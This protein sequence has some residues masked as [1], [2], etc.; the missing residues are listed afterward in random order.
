M[1]SISSFEAFT[2]VTRLSERVFRVVENDRFGQFPFMYVIIGS[3]KCILIDTG[4]GSSDYRQFVETTINTA[5]LPYLIVNTHI[6]FDHVGGNHFFE[7]SPGF[8]GT[9]IGGNARVFSENYPLNSLVLAHHGAK[10]ESFKIDRWLQENELIY[11]DDAHPDENSALRV[12][13]T[14]GH[15]PDSIALYL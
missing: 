7:N 5:K 8:L 9:C 4:C 12:L 15:T 2:N 3:D 14:P 6:H 13:F 1:S 11:L 10:L